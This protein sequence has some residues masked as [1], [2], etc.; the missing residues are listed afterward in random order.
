MGSQHIDVASCHNNIATLIHD[1]G[2]LEQV[3]VYHELDLAVRLEKLGY[4]HIGAATSYNNIA[5]VL[6]AQGDLEQAKEYNERALA[7]QIETSGD[8]KLGVNLGK[9]GD[10]KR[11][12]EVAN[13]FDENKGGYSFGIPC[14]E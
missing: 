9:L 6:C 8:G 4:L 3:K 10:S 2:D 7:I 12:K 14:R 13:T 11:D 1:Q 5:T